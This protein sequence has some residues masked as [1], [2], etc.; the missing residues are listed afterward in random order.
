M[1]NLDIAALQEVNGG[2]NVSR[3]WSLDVLYSQ[4]HHLYD[5]KNLTVVCQIA[6]L[7]FFLGKQK[8][9]GDVPKA[10]SIT[11]FSALPDFCRKFEIVD[12]LL[13]MECRSI[14]RGVSF[15]K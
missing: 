5:P 7:F 9:L 10:P 11:L 15:L 3:T 1:A 8:A 13:R 14:L 6:R 12:L 4:S 2:F